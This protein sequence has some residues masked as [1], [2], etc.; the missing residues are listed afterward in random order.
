MGAVRNIVRDSWTGEIRKFGV[1]TEPEGTVLFYSPQDVA[2]IKDTGIKL[3]IVFGE[4]NVSVQYGS[5]VFDKNGIFIGTVNYLVSDSL[6]GA[7]KSFKVKTDYDDHALI[8]SLEDVEKTTPE[9]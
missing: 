3:K 2:E 8:F 1:T 5:E 6:T 7:I 9:E 4:A